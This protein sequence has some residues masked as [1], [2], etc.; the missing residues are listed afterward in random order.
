MR[1]PTS[2]I[3]PLTL[4]LVGLLAG[5]ALTPDYERPELDLPETWQRTDDMGESIANL[6]W[7]EIYQD[8]VLSRLIEAALAENQ[9]LALAL[10]R[11]DIAGNIGIQANVVEMGLH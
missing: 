7:W 4:L 2:R 9:N 1:W 8:E 5:C 11:F 6:D 10:A 3:V